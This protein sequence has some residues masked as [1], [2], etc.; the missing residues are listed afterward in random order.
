MKKIEIWIPGRLPGENEIIKAAKRSGKGTSNQYTKLKK[1]WSNY[2]ADIVK[3]CDLEPAES[4]FVYFEWV[5]QDQRRDKD[6]IAAAKKFVFD[7]MVKAGFIENDGWK[8]VIGWRESFSVNRKGCGQGCGVNLMITA[9]DDEDM[10]PEDC[11]CFD[12]PI[13]KNVMADNEEDWDCAC[14]SGPVFDEVAC[15][16]CQYNDRCDVALNPEI[17]RPN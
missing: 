11:I 4:I 17:Y 2:V 16:L 10:R 3:A 9:L 15:S 1:D 8:Q 7:G 13:H 5:D 12:C 6:N 14:E